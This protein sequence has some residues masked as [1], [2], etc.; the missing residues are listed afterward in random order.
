MHSLMH[1]LVCSCMHA[2]IHDSS[3]HGFIHSFTDPLIK[4][5]P[6]SLSFFFLSL[7]LSLS[8]SPS[9]SLLS[10][11]FPLSISHAFIHLLFQL[12]SCIL[13][14][15]HVFVRACMY[16]FVHS[17]MIHVF[18]HSGPFTDSSHL[19]L[20]FSVSLPRSLAL[21][22]LSLCDPFT[23]SSHLSRPLCSL[24]CSLTLSPSFLFFFLSLVSLLINSFIYL[25]I[26]RFIHH[27]LILSFGHASLY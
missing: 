18:I 25:L 20:V 1:S 17:F 2:F 8:L 4:F 16:S 15:I 11:S 12:H 22:S 7:P 5:S 21:L 6:L 19:S 10:L 13:L 3:I 14:C 24:P 9:V 27:P 26:D 23:D